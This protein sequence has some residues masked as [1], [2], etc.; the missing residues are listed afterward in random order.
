[1]RDFILGARYLVTGFKLLFKAKIRRYVILP[2]SIN[3]II[4]TSLFIFLSFWITKLN[5]W[6]LLLLPT[7][8]AWLHVIVWLIFF[9]VFLLLTT[10]TF[11][12]F[13]NIVM[14]PFNSI[15]SEEVII[16]LLGRELERRSLLE[17]VKNIPRSIKNQ[18]KI[19]F[20]YLTRSFFILILLFIPIVQ[21]FVPIISFLFQAWIMSFT[22]IDYPLQQKNFTFSEIKAWLYKRRFKAYGFGSGT[23]ICT[24][25][26]VVNFLVIPAAVIGATIWWVEDEHSPLLS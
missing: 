25:I 26:P 6:I 5:H 16:S 17:D 7:W 12:M 21:L 3:I 8:L 9:I 11:V 22:Y 24:M 2:L 20:Y 10:A 4:F 19:T 13:A 15:L 18:I 1:M 14:A 23:L